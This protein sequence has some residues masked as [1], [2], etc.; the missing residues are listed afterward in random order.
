MELTVPAA[1]TEPLSVHPRA[2]L[3]SVD[4]LRGLVMVLM[5]VDHVRYPYF[6]N[7]PIWAENNQETYLALFLTR[8]I[9]HF[10]APLFF[11]LAGT[12]AYLST[13]RGKTVPELSKFL[14]TR[15][16]WLVFLELTVIGFAWSFM[17]GWGF[18]GVIWSLGWSMVV[19]S[20]VVRLPLRWVAVF[21]VGIMMFHHLA[22]G[23]SKQSWGSLGFV[24]QAL[25]AGGGARADWLPGGFFPFLFSIFPLAGVMAAGYALGALFGEEPEKRREWLFR[26]GLGMTVA[27]IVLRLTN[28][29]GHPIPP[30]GYPGP[31]LF[32]LQ[33]SWDRTVISFLNVQK[34]PTSLQFLLMTIGPSLMLL[35][36][37]DRMNTGSIKGG[38]LWDKIIVF[39]RVPMFYYVLHL[40]FIHVLVIVIGWVAGQPIEWLW[41][42][43][44]PFVREAPP[45]YGYGLPE[46]Y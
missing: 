24:W 44:L 27:F 11:L 2:R 13:T 34:Y 38:W 39:G 19:L 33:D 10:C 17:P 46:T 30:Q 6:T 5:A 18:G 35:A 4:L 1:G 3:D 32:A 42:K 43:P 16:L 36:W 20:L 23:I 29:Y 9:T 26:I 12:G 14:W 25:Y 21:G 8:W 31:G 7:I 37:F 41:G 28:V 15:G 45:E 22:E 40:L